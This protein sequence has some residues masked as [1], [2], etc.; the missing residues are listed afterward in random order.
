M[1]GGLNNV[2]LAST[3][4]H[5]YI[6]FANYLAS[7]VCSSIEEEAEALR[8]EHLASLLSWFLLNNVGTKE[9]HGQKSYSLVRF[10]KLSNSIQN[11][12]ESQVKKSDPSN[13]TAKFLLATAFAKFKEIDSLLPNLTE[14]YTRSSL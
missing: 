10:A 2:K 13:K 7:M 11:I 3:R 1:V 5:Q 14:K 9:I 12:I 4:T 6:V 8:E